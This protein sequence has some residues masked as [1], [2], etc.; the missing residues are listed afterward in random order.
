MEDEAAVMIE[1]GETET[2]EDYVR[3]VS[4]QIAGEILELLEDEEDD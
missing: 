2:K 3:R 1:R 4:E